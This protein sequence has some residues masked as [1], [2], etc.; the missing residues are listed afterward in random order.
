MDADVYS[1]FNYIEDV[2][3]GQLPGIAYETGMGVPLTQSEYYE[4]SG[5]DRSVPLP[6][7]DVRS[8]PDESRRFYYVHAHI[9]KEYAALEDV[10][11]ASEDA[12]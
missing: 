6:N 12:A 2:P 3:E 10:V 8:F 1:G 5:G 11:H 4:R 9:A 7:T